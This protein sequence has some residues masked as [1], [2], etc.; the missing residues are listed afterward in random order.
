[1]IIQIKSKCRI[2]LPTLLGAKLIIHVKTVTFAIFAFP[3]DSI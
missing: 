3:I 2:K 1:M